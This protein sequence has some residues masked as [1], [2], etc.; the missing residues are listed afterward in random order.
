MRAE[1]LG[2]LVLDRLGGSDEAALVDVLDELD[3]DL[4]ELAKR[5]MLERQ[6]AAVCTHFFCS[7]LKLVQA[8]SLTQITLL[9]ASCSVSDMIGATS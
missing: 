9:L 3:A 4:L 8:R 5:L 6:S 2:D 7:S 1:L